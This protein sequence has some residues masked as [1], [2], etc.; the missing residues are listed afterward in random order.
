M[1]T[2]F[3]RQFRCRNDRYAVTNSTWWWTSPYTHTYSI[4]L[5]ITKFPMYVGKNPYIG[6][7]RIPM[8]QANKVQLKGYIWPTLMPIALLC[9]YVCAAADHYLSQIFITPRHA[10][11]LTSSRAQC[12]AIFFLYIIIS[13]SLLFTG[14]QWIVPGFWQD[15]G[16]SLAGC[17]MI[18]GK[19]SLVMIFAGTSA[20]TFFPLGL[21]AIFRIWAG[22]FSGIK[23]SCE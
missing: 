19:I 17:S 22:I 13:M 6:M 20:S 10:I 11:I 1:W 18:S 21:L 15:S 5:R 14:S 16:R 2:D 7:E 4:V 8:E 12:R 9:K 3:H 23:T